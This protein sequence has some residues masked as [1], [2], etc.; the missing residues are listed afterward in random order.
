MT[1]SEAGWLQVCRTC[2]CLYWAAYVASTGKV[3]RFHPV[4][5]EQPH[6]CPKENHDA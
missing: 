5:R 6:E 4:N 3:R 2:K 1:H